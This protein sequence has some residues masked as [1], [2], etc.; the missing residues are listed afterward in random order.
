MK[1]F[2]INSFKS[3]IFSPTPI[4]FTG[5]FNSFAIAK[6]IAPFAEPSSLVKATE[7]KFT[8]SVKILACFKQF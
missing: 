1:S 3:S 7:V 5:S 2:G 4:N 6:T 8:A